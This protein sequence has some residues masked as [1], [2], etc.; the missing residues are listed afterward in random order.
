MIRVEKFL[1][2]HL[3]PNIN[4]SIENFCDF[5]DKREQILLDKLKSILQN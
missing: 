1:K 5:I 2:S 4:L 3:I